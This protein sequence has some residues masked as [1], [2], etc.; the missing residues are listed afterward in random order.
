MRAGALTALHAA[1]RTGSRSLS[2]AALRDVL[3]TLRALLSDKAG[4][5]VRG[6]AMCLVALADTLPRDQGGAFAT[7]AEI[8]ASVQPALKALEG[9]DHATR[10][11]LSDLCAALLAMTQDERPTT[12]TSQ[13]TASSTTTTATTG[14]EKTAAHEDDGLPSAAPGRLNADEGASTTATDAAAST[15]GGSGERTLCSPRGMLALLSGPY[16]RPTSS[17]RLRNGILDVY[18]ALFARLGP[19]WVEMHCAEVI[20]HLVSQVACGAAAGSGSSGWNARV[21]DKAD[22]NRAR[23]DALAARHAAALLL[24]D[25]LGKRVLSEPG[26]VVCVREL[27]R[28]YL[29]KWPALMPGTAPPS[30][31]ALVVALDAV[32]ALLKG[33]GSV[34]PP[35]QDTVHEHVVRLASHPSFSVHIAAA[36]ALSA[37]CDA[38]PARLAPTLSQLTELL[39]RELATLQTTGPHTGADVRR[40]AVGLAHA[41]AALVALVPR[42][43]LYVSFDVS[44]R[45]MSLAVQ[46]LKQ[47]AQHD[48]HVSATEI[49]VAWSLAAAL[50]AL[51]PNFVRLHVPQLMI[52]WRAALP[53]PPTHGKEAAN[54]PDNEWA[55]LL[56]V[57]EC[58]LSAILS[59]VQHDA[60][61]VTDDVARRIVALL[62]HAL[63]FSNQFASARPSVVSPSASTE[64]LPTA[65]PAPGAAGSA[66]SLLDRDIMLRRRITQCFVALGNHPATGAY[67][68][69]LLAQAVSVMSDPDRYAGT[70][71]VQAAIHAS[72]GQYNGV[73]QDTDGFGFGVSSLMRPDGVA[74]ATDAPWK[75]DGRVNRDTAERAI[76]DLLQSSIL[77]A[78]EFDPLA[79][80]SGAYLPPP[81]AVA[82]TDA[83]VELFATHFASQTGHNQTL[84]LQ[85][86]V[87][88]SRVA[89]L[90]RNPGRRM[91]IMANSTTAILMALRAC[92]TPLDVGAANTL[93]DALR[94]PLL[95]PDARLRSAASEAVGR[96]A[97][98]TG[99]AFMAGQVQ[100]CVNQVVSSTDPASRAGCALALAEIYAHVGSLAASPILKTVVDVL[101]SLSADP[102]PLVHYYALQ[103]L[104]HVVSS[105][106]LAYAPFTTSTLGLLAKLYMSE[107]HEPE[108]G[109]PG[110]VNLRSDLPALQAFCRVIDSLIR[111]IGP[112]LQPERGAEPNKVQEL[113]M[114]LVREFMRESAEGVAVEATK[115]TQHILMFAPALLDQAELVAT[116]RSRLGSSRQPLRLAAVNSVYQLVQRDA[117]LMSKLGGDGLVQDLFA[118]LDDDPSIEGVRAAIKSWLA[119][120]ADANPSGWIDLCQRIMSRSD[121]SQRAL[122]A[123][124]QPAQLEGFDEESQGLGVDAGER[125]AAKTQ[126]TSRWRTQLFALEC[127]HHVFVTVVKRGRPEHFDVVRAR[128]L[129]ANRRSLLISRVADLI[130]MAFTASTAQVMQIRLEGLVV[131]RDVIQ[132]RVALFRTTAPELTSAACRALHVRRTSTLR[133][134]SCSSSI[135]HRLLRRSRLRSPRTRTPRSSRPPSRSA[136]SLSAR[137]S[138][139]KSA[140]WAASSSC[141]PPRS[142]L[143]K[144][145]VPARSTATSAHTLLLQRQTCRRWETSRT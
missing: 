138:S 30:K 44:A 19:V 36:R 124:A 26:Q 105:A 13:G 101:V 134:R 28:V 130:K 67:Q 76:E 123:T 21:A 37:L 108:G 60:Q 64:S 133:R 99:T 94:E 7:A 62:S 14:E 52:L 77:G 48:L 55:F 17:R 43:A 80:T 106:S 24:A 22:R 119:Q 100:F 40:K 65:T 109:T 112:E 66:L 50:M 23:Y 140:R 107:T 144:V 29:R 97:A 135:R 42:H 143:A 131:L 142:S 33:L 129:R 83:A 51:G 47:S 79:L 104:S 87:A 102:H 32:A 116:L 86:L 18:A 58:A 98:L 120:T 113:V 16:N 3:K 6:S 93:K 89:R 75:A 59:F 54:R 20:E 45:L 126:T 41:L 25:V 35:V 31:Q 2:D 132:V 95:H 69:S 71:P 8:D 10:R 121:A 63:A 85:Q 53:K 110:S 111:V 46:L 34:P 78:A 49:N 92:R 61:L 90:E 1:L 82:L 128:A 9:A 70:S 137:A 15:S 122:D 57:R 5:V 117:V 88:N 12:T 56:H 72:A 39:N 91:A 11:S 114:I 145:C 73:W 139:K 136:P 74:N 84:L 115:A 125:P 96:L 4:A 141:S 118:L 27:A 127:L 81:P 103:A 68:T 38:A